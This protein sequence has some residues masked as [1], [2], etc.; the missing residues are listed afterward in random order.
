MKQQLHSGPRDARSRIRAIAINA[1]TKFRRTTIKFPITAAIRL[2]PGR[3]SDQTVMWKLSLKNDAQIFLWRWL[4][5]ARGVGGREGKFVVWGSVLIECHGRCDMF[6]HSWCSE[7]A[8]VLCRAVENNCA[9]CCTSL[10]WIVLVGFAFSVSIS[11]SKDYE[12]L[13]SHNKERIR[14]RSCALQCPLSKLEAH[15]EASISF[16]MQVQSIDST[17]L[18]MHLR[19][20]RM[21]SSQWEDKQSCNTNIFLFNIPRRKLSIAI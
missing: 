8:I 17:P 13:L 18:S 15:F 21:T 14:I 9:P 7:V 12:L 2:K 4:A 1:I 3:D 10:F 20:L 16:R 5:F 6:H 11:R 19:L